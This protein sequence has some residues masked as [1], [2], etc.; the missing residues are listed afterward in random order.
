M[1]TQDTP[2]EPNGWMGPPAF[3]FSVQG[4]SVETAAFSRTFKALAT[5]IVLGCSVAIGQLWWHPERGTG[6]ITASWFLAGWL[7]MS[8]TWWFILRSTTCLDLQG[9]HQSWIWDKHMSFDELAYGKLIRVKKLEWLI[10]PRLYVRTLDAK[11]T[12]IYAA[13]PEMLVQFERL[14]AELK[15]FRQ[16]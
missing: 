11:F 3:R 13:S 9:L 12:V 1:T 8:I 4:G 10:A 7:L 15:A 14:C 2:V 16:F 5:T 6:G